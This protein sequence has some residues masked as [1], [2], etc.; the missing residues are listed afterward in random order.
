MVRL[1]YLQ[2]AFLPAAL[3]QSNTLPSVGSVFSHFTRLVS[4]ALRRDG[5]LGRATLYRGRTT[6]ARRM[7][8]TQASRHRAT[9]FGERTAHRQTSRVMRTPL[10][11]GRPFLPVLLLVLLRQPRQTRGHRMAMEQRLNAQFFQH[12]ETPSMRRGEQ[13]RSVTPALRSL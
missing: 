8:R 10:R 11:S 5:A 9:M 6:P 1:L 13:F 7:V 4:Q 3:P 12:P 2:P